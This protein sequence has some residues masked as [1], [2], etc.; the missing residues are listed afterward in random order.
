MNKLLYGR[1]ALFLLFSL[2]GFVPVQAQESATK[3]LYGKVSIASPTAASLG[4]YAD[5]P[6]NYYT[7]IPQISVPLYT[8][9]EGPLS[10]PIGLSYHAGG[11]KVQEPASWVGAGWA[12]NAG[13]V[14]TRTVMG[15]PDE[16]G[17]SAYHY[18]C[19]FSDYG[20]NSYLKNY[21]TSLWPIPAG[22][23]FYKDNTPDVY[24][25]QQGHYDTE[26]DLFFF[27]F[28]G[29]SGKFFFSDDR[30]PVLVD[31]NDLKIEYYYPNE[32]AP[33][34]SGA[35]TKSANIQGFIITT[36]NGDKYYF[37]ITDNA[38]VT[39]TSPVETTFPFSVDSNGLPDQVYSSY[40]LSKIV[41]ADG[42]HTIQFI[43]QAEKYS[44]YT[45]SMIPI[46]GNNIQPGNLGTG[47]SGK[48][49]GLIKNNIE[50]V[51]L[52][53]IKFSNGY[54]DFNASQT[55]RLDLGQYTINVGVMSDVPND[56]AKALNDVAIHGPDLCKTIAFGYSYFEDNTTQLA[57]NLGASYNII[58][59]KKRLRLNSVVE[60]SC[61][62]TAVTNPWQ[63]KYYSDFLTRRLSFAQDHWGFY[64]GQVNNNAL[65][66]LI[67][68][69]SINS[70]VP[71]QTTNT[72]TSDVI[73][74]AN[75]DPAWP[76]M[77]NG[78][79]TK[80]IYPTGG[81]SD[82]VYE[83]NTAW[84]SYTKYENRP[85]PGAASAAGKQAGGTLTPPP[86]T[87][88]ASPNGYRLTLRL[89][90]DPSN[91]ASGTGTA[92]FSGPGRSLSVSKDKLYDEVVLPPSST[93]QTW[94]LRADDA[95]GPVYLAEAGVYERVIVN[96][97]ENSM[98]GGLRIKTLATQAGSATP[99]MVTNYSYEQNG[100]STATLYSRPRYV[101]IIRNDI[102]AKYGWFPS[103]DNTG[104]NLNTLG[105]LAPDN[106]G[107]GTTFLASP[108]PLVPMST[109]QGNH[110]GYDQVTV[111]QSGNGRSEY[112]YYG[113]PNDKKYE[114]VCYRVVMPTVCDPKIPGSPAVPLPY[115]FN[116][117]QLKFERIFNEAGQLLKQ[118][119]YT[120]LYDSSKTLTPVYIVK[121]VGGAAYL[122]NYYERRSYWKTQM[123]TIE[124]TMDANGQTS[125]QIKKTSKYNSPYHHQLT[126]LTTTFSVNDVVETR[127]KYVNDFRVA[128]SDALNDG[129]AVYTAACIECDRQ[130]AAAAC[131]DLGCLSVA[132]T[133]NRV[134]RANARKA[135]VAY[136][137]SNFTNS[138]NNFQ[139]AH[140]A[141]KNS[142][143]GVLKPLLQLQDNY[144]NDLVETTRWRNGQLLNAS[145]TTFGPGI[146]QGAAMYPAKI[147]A[148]PLASPL[149]TFTPATI[150]GNTVSTDPH[151]A[152]T[153]ETVLKFDV[154]NLVELQPRT[155][156]ITAYLW[157]YANT[158]PVAQATG[159]TYAALSAAYGGT[160]GEPTALRGTPSLSRALVTTYAHK[161]LVGLTSQTD[162]SGRKVTYEY[163]ALGRL[164][165]TRDEQGRILSQQQYHYAGQ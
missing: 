46:I 145:Y 38:T 106:S 67:P 57:P 92:G 76:A 1:I 153:P 112:Y 98:A 4:K 16:K 101:Q 5:I 94:T 63:F 70:L 44:Y 127:N 122:P 7:G 154:G 125:L 135:Y 81:S 20:Y 13:G 105:C 93:A 64:N 144:S 163:D 113:P 79:L 55:P 48:E 103:Y 77:E 54:V 32:P 49:Y 107:A 33:G 87:L 18:L 129:S 90:L 120:Y 138:T 99:P 109:T 8:I 100:Q 82:F 97:Q 139:T 95:S 134:C 146:S 96:G 52:T 35:N 110:I 58:T 17:T 45:I 73:P 159:V 147:F 102:V 128:A 36:P 165:R 108:S 30:T 62:G 29:Y 143:D 83:P 111:T 137:R 84:I 114:D 89:T 124:T 75:R 136:R 161:P 61:D 27:N 131:A 28:N 11:M 15:G 47:V 85:V 53:K 19:H 117:G 80:I 69:F 9:K 40:Y 116:R 51:R 86:V 104:T 115:D 59:D 150:N 126:Q 56:E 91:T 31:G 123:E 121:N 21:T 155:G 22:G 148:L 6:V 42:V 157:G 142:A 68:T 25:L 41:A 71:A 133:S 119:Q 60:S 43:Y 78:V 3:N 132:Y 74:G 72:I 164:V 156:I 140:D 2:V 39:G 26:P 34:I 66:T 37:G 65:N 88:P 10:L 160:G 151:Y 158:L 130:L 141:A 50:G 118:N 152:A 14:I 12:L 23:D 24:N 162:P 149:A